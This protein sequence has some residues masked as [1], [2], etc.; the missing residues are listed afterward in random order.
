MYIYYD[1]SEEVAMVS[2]GKIKAPNFKYISKTLTKDEEEK[3][4]QNWKG[5]IK[6]G[7]LTLEKP[8]HIIEE[9]K[10][11]LLLNIKIKANMITDENAKSVANDILSLIEA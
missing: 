3:F 6:N 4:E 7:K 10:K 1:N 11:D 8:P 9:D 5:K 2:A